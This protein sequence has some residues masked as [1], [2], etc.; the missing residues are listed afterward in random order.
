MFSSHPYQSDSVSCKLLWDSMSITLWRPWLMC[1]SVSEWC[2]MTK[3]SLYRPKI[4]LSFPNSMELSNIRHPRI[5]KHLIHPSS[6]LLYFLLSSCSSILWKQDKLFQQV[7][8]LFFC[9]HFLILHLSLLPSLP[10]MCL[11]ICLFIS[12]SLTHTPETIWQRQT[13]SRGWKEGNKGRHNK[14]LYERGGV[15]TTT[16]LIN[17]ILLCIYY[18]FGKLPW[19]KVICTHEF[20]FQLNFEI[21]QGKDQ[22]SVISFALIQSTPGT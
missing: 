22:V 6:F 21:F 17:F 8:I 2:Y 16:W 5:M 11:S 19:N 13:L 1:G 20:S 10:S 4:L 14:K 7:F 18:T 15:I 9:I 12:L 3:E